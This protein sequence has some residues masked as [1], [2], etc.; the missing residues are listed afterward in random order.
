MK[1]N[2]ILKLIILG[3]LAIWILVA[4]RIVINTIRDTRALNNKVDSI[5]TSNSINYSYTH[6]P[7]FENK[8]PEDGIDEA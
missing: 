5:I 8:S 2:N 6:I 7:T 4:S 1:F 3:S